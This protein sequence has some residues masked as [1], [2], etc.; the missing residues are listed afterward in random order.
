MTEENKN[1][2]DTITRPDGSTYLEEK[3]VLR[4]GATPVKPG[5]VTWDLTCQ[6]TEPSTTGTALDK[7]S[8]WHYRAAD[9][10]NTERRWLS[11][12]LRIVTYRVAHLFQVFSKADFLFST[13]N[14]VVHSEPGKYC[15]SIR[16]MRAPARR[17][18]NVIHQP[19]VYA[20]KEELTYSLDPSIEDLRSIP[21]NGIVREYDTLKIPT[22][23]LRFLHI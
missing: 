3:S 6:H 14:V 8:P 4:N 16:R 12:V 22:L 10:Q 5:K 11:I 13:C 17:F 19:I 23:L 20:L 2:D 15:I 9:L 21:M 7:G 18:D 1:R